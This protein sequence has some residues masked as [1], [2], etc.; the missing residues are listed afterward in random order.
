MGSS[1]W[2]LGE[3]I[4][5]FD[6]EEGDI[7][8]WV[9]A[10]QKFKPA[11]PFSGSYNDLTDVPADEDTKRIQDQ[12]DFALTQTSPPPQT[13]LLRTNTGAGDTTG[14]TGDLFP[15]SNDVYVSLRL[16]DG[17]DQSASLP[18][19]GSGAGTISIIIDGTTYTAAYTDVTTWVNGT[20]FIRFLDARTGD[21]STALDD[22]VGSI[23]EVVPI[24]FVPEDIPLAEGDVLQWVDAEQKFKPAQLPTNVVPP[25]DSVNGQTGEVSLDVRSLTDYAPANVFQSYRFTPGNASD[26]GTYVRGAFI[27]FNNRDADGQDFAISGS[28]DYFN[29]A[30]GQTIYIEQEGQWF[31]TVISSFN[32]SGS[33]RFAAGGFSAIDDTKEIRLV[34]EFF[35]V[36]ANSLE[37]PPANDDV[38]SWSDADQAFKPGPISTVARSGSYND[39]A[40]LPVLI[41]RIQDQTDYQA[42]I[43]NQAYRFV[44]A[45]G[46]ST[47]QGEWLK[48][49]Y[50][51][52]G[53][54]DA[55]GQDFALG[56]STGDFY[57]LANGQ[58]VYAFQDGQWFSTVI[59]NFNNSGSIRFS[60]GGLAGLDDN[61]EIL[62]VSE[63]FVDSNRTIG[64][65]PADNQILTWS[66]ADA[67]WMPAVAASSR[68][69]GSDDFALNGVFPTQFVWDFGSN[70]TAGFASNGSI[71]GSNTLFVNKTDKNGLTFDDNSFPDSGTIYGSVDGGVTWIS[72]P[73]AFDDDFTDANRVAI[74]TELA[75]DLGFGNASLQTILISVEADPEVPIDVPLAEGDV[76]R[77]DNTDEKF[78]P[79]SDLISLSTLQ[80]V[81]ADSTDFADFQARIAAL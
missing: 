39:L 25:V 51:V 60:T 50:I 67:K 73:Y 65:P 22:S 11:Q 18:A 54:R 41:D 26:A 35:V 75:V 59:S 20:D 17:T 33:I 27:V 48:G 57:N 10:E 53:S 7:L 32:S 78:K 52:F 45:A 24:D 69:Q 13:A 56:G 62:L 55:D 70:S 38:L 37:L 19:V 79:A 71:V 1:Q 58:T 81:V 30:D 40:D 74:D 28:N 6:L 63:N 2:D 3:V 34:S 64:M 9:D 12:D 76:L 80:Q 47:G 36:S 61:K 16:A 72:R 15:F 46:A 21:L 43:Y 68:I 49:A 44:P 14:N 77:W 31:S 42:E 23:V 8:Q 66:A 5:Y 4:Q 29:L